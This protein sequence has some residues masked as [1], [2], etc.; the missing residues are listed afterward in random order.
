[1][2]GIDKQILKGEKYSLSDSDILRITDNK[3]NIIRYQDLENVNDIDEILEPYG[4]CIILYQLEEGYGHWCALVKK[5]HN[6]LEFFGSYG[7][8]IDE[9]LKFSKYNLRR[10]Q[11]QMV[12]HLTHL[13][14][15]SKYNITSNTVKLQKN[16]A[17][18]NTCG[19]WVSLRVRF[20][21]VPINRFIELFTQNTH[22]DADFWVTALTLLV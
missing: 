14:E 9:Q 7:L 18:V 6:K 17:D 21:D 10:H 16:K 11:G 19:R 12:P 15:H 13:I 8:S 20:R 3:C 2:S 1:M 22:Y 5:G 4:A